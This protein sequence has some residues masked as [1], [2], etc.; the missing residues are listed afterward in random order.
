MQAM[1]GNVALIYTINST[2]YIIQDMS[3]ILMA[4]Y[5]LQ[6]LEDCSDYHGSIWSLP[7]NVWEKV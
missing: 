1:G 3:N 5:N 7:D 2:F 4:Y 6:N